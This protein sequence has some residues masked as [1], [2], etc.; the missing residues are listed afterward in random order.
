MCLHLGSLSF[1]NLHFL[2]IGTD[3]LLEILDLLLELEAP[4]LEALVLLDNS[5]VLEVVF[6]QTVEDDL[7]GLVLEM[8]G[9]QLPTH[10]VDPLAELL[11]P[12]GAVFAGEGLCDGRRRGFLLFGRTRLHLLVI[13]IHSTSPPFA[14]FT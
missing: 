14:L 9:V 12:G 2:I 3:A 7:V 8:E 13:L 4:A 1:H 11:P 5:V 10:L 6:G